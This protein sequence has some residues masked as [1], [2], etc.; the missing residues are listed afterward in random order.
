MYWHLPSTIHY[1]LAV[2]GNST[3]WNSGDV[4]RYPGMN[5]LW[6]GFIKWFRVAQ[7]EIFC[8]WVTALPPGVNQEWLFHFHPATYHLAAC[9][10]K[11]HWLAQSLKSYITSLP[12]QGQ[13][14]R[15]Q[16]KSPVKLLG[17][18]AVGNGCHITQGYWLEPNFHLQATP[19]SSTS[20]LQCFARSPMY[21]LLLCSLNHNNTLLL[22]PGFSLM[23]SHPWQSAVNKWIYFEIFS[24]C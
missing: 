10:S 14:P 24:G 2:H 3:S 18:E 15:A 9:L 20:C 17:H 21:P 5:F 19:V 7:R 22:H 16:G 6:F 23:T 12:E 4:S 1:S 13:R 11:S 8:F